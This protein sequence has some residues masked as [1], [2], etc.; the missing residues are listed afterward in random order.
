MRKVEKDD[1]FMPDMPEVEGAEH[2][3]GYLFEIGPVLVGS[4]GDTPLSHAEIAAWQRNTGV[5]LSSWEARSMLR[6]S[7]DY[8]AQNQ[9]AQKMDCKSPVEED[10]YAPLLS[11]QE[12]AKAMQSSIRALVK[13]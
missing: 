5:E 9:K 10:Q 3:L 13:L 12:M 8:L 7:R 4:M 11:A 2:V 6:L 1:E